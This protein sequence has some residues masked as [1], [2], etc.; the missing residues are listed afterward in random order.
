MGFY[1]AGKAS[2]FLCTFAYGQARGGN[3]D[4]AHLR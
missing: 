3:G 2:A 1:P 4:W